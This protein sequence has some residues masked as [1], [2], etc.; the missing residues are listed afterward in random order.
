MIFED[1]SNQMEQSD[2]VDLIKNVEVPVCLNLALCYLK[3]E[4]YHYA[5]KYCT[6][7]LDKNLKPEQINGGIG[8]IEKA[9]YRRG[10]SYFK[11]GDLKKAKADFLRANEIIEDAQKVNPNIKKSPVVA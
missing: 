7:V 4:K 2:A 10:M 6:Q 11:I 1:Q 5:I 8:S 9:Y 3:T